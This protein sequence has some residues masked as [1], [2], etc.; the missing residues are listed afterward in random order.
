MRMDTTTIATLI[1]MV[2][3]A[4]GGLAAAIKILFSHFTKVVERNE[5][6]A[7]A[8]ER[9]LAAVINMERSR[10]DEATKNWNEVLRVALDENTAALNEIRPTFDEA[11]EMLAAARGEAVARKSRS[12]EHRAP[13][14]WGRHPPAPPGRAAV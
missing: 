14:T 9:E 10:L 1:A 13:A 5:A 8:R 11:V 12:G 6:R 2:A 4:A 3:A 7:D